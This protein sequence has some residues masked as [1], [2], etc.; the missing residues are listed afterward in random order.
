[1]KRIFTGLMIVL[2]CVGL[3]ISLTSCGGKSK[4]TVYANSHDGFLNIREEPSAK[5]AV[6][7]RMY[8]G[9]QGAISLGIE[10]GNWV[11]VERRG[12]YG[13]DFSTIG[14]VHRNYLQEMPSS[15]ALMNAKDLSGVW[16]AQTPFGNLSFTTLII[17]DDGRYVEGGAGGLLCGAG[18]WT[19]E[20]GKL[21]L[22]QYYNMETHKKDKDEK[23]ITV[24]R[25]NQ[26]KKLLDCKADMVYHKE[27]FVSD[28]TA[29]SDA[30][31]KGR[32]SRNLYLKANEDVAA[33]VD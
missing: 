15:P 14:W 25:E 11:Q 8:N 13:G 4:K 19:L 17:F 23:V 21:T 1:M 2:A 22:K 6:V 32:L 31:F 7:G 33:I 18:R 20:G 9:D 3:S 27:A 5:S 28:K 29:Q 24:V 12:S 10:V 16:I 26:V 30:N